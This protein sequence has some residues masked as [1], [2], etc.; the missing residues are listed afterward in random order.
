MPAAEGQRQVLQQQ[1]LTLRAQ[2]VAH[3]GHGLV[4]GQLHGPVGAQ[5]SQCLPECAVA[6]AG[7][8][9]QVIALQSDTVD[10]HAAA[11]DVEQHVGL[12]VGRGHGVPGRLQPVGTRQQL[13]QARLVARTRLGDLRWRAVPAGQAP[14]QLGGLHLAVGRVDHQVPVATRRVHFGVELHQEGAAPAPGQRLGLHP[15][16]AAELVHLLRRQQ[17]AGRGRQPGM[18]GHQRMEGLLGLRPVPDLRIERE[19]S[20]PAASRGFVPL[21][22]IG[23]AAQGGRQPGPHIRRQQVQHAVEHLHRHWSAHRPQ[24]CAA[25]QAEIGGGAPLLL[26]HQPPARMQLAKADACARQRLPHRPLR[27]RPAAAVGCE[28]LPELGALPEI[29]PDPA[30][31]AGVLPAQV[32]LVHRL[33]RQEGAFRVTAARRQRPGGGH[34]G[35]QIAVTRQ[36]HEEGRLGVAAVDAVPA[37]A[38][39]LDKAAAQGLQRRGAGGHAVLNGSSRWRRH[40]PGSGRCPAPCQ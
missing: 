16:A 40:E 36:R 20:Q 15:T 17:G 30:A 33:V 26:E 1:A 14:G 12:V 35:P 27:R 37:L 22:G 8:G 9:T 2:R 24:P 18:P 32:D 39:L 28:G 5:A 13:G 10:E 29:D 19:Q 25:Q 7:K 31:R 6:L 4:T 38:V 23:Q 11:H 21:V 3:P 34:E